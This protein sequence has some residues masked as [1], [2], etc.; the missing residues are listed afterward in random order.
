MHD[1]YNLQTNKGKLITAGKLDKLLES[2]NE[3]N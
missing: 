3:D 1:I 2:L